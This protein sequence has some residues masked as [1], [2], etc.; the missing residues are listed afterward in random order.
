MYVVGAAL[1]FIGLSLL[2]GYLE[3]SM[4]SG[5]NYGPTLTKISS[6]GANFRL[7][8]S[9]ISLALSV[10]FILIGM[11]PSKTDKKLK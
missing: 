8:F 3:Y 9:V 4:S 1:F 6:E 11:R 10:I 2:S 7:L 5:S